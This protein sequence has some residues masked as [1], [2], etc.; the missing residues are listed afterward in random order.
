MTLG[1]WWLIIRLA[2]LVITCVPGGGKPCGIAEPL[3][4]STNMSRPEW[5]LILISVIAALWVSKMMVY[6][7]RDFEDQ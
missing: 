6:P 4:P 7:N 2:N 5:V 1:A 3:I